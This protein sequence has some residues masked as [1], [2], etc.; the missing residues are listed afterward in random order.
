[1]KNAKLL[2]VIMIVMAGSITGAFFIW[3]V[4]SIS[5][6]V[7]QRSS[8]ID[9]SKLKYNIPIQDFNKI[10]IGMVKPT[11]TDAVYNNKFYLFYF[12]HDD[13]PS[14][15]IVTKDLDLLN[16]KILYRQSGTIISVNS[17][18]HLIK[19]MKRIPYGNQVNILTDVDVD[20]GEI[21]DNQHLNLFNTLILGHQEYVSQ[22]E[23]ESKTI[24][25]KWRN[26]DSFR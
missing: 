7:Q 17:M 4:S 18:L 16:S 23:Y 6:L 9:F 5:S 10:K 2:V 21:F 8:T 14:K 19:D 15:V 11:F 3:L 12:K 24:C 22:K 26:N 1:M 25:I 13:V 20:K